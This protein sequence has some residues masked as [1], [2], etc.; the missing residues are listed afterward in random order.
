M[1][2]SIV[3]AMAS[4]NVIGR[5]GDMPWR[6]R[7]DLQ[8]FKVLTLGKP[9]IMGRK[10]FE[11]I[12]KPLPGRT[13]I[14]ITRNPDFKPDGVSVYSSLEKAIADFKTIGKLDGTEEICIIGGG[15]IYHQS[16]DFADTIYATHVMAEIEG[17]TVFPKID[18]QWE[19]DGAEYGPPVD[20]HNTHTTIYV[21]YTRVTPNK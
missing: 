10:T 21:N 4:N 14:V 7:G 12:G 20:D 19:Y 2:I 3:V 11:S 13:N 1:K 9:V 5:D 15:E 18:S 16:M 8:R 6:L 17:D